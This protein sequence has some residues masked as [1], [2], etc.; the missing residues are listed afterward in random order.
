MKIAYLM[1]VHQNPRLLKRAVAA[2][3]C[4]GCG[5]FIHVDQ[6]VDARSFSDIGGNTIFFCKQRVPVYWGEFS[7]VQATLMLMREALGSAEGYDYFVLLSGSDYPLR[8]GTYIRRFLKEN[9]GSE[10][11]N[12]VKMPAPGFPLSKINK[13]RYPSDKPARRFASRTLAKIGLAQ[14]DFRRSLRGLD[15][16]GGT[17]W[18]TI[19]RDA[20]QYIAG[21]VRL[22]PHLEKYFQ[23]AFTSDEMFFHTILGN[24]PFRTRVRRSLVY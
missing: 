14:R 19:S 16:Y 6:R 2:L 20:A 4:D 11:I 3:S 12:L 18:W 23:K 22:N 9:R 8:A 5:F 21:S 13:L 17:Q 24:S 1:L 10:F 15:A 7:L